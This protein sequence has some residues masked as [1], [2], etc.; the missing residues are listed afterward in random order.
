MIQSD[1]TLFRLG[2]FLILL[3][4]GWSAYTYVHPLQSLPSPIYGGDFYYQ[5]GHVHHFL[6]GGGFMESS[7]LFDAL[8]TYM[9]LY[10]WL[11]AQSA[12]L[13][14]WDAMEAMFF[15]SIIFKLLSLFLWYLLLKELFPK[16]PLFHLLGLSFVA[17]ST[18]VILKYTAFAYSIILP[19][20]L[21]ALYRFLTQRSYLNALFLGVVYGVSALSYTILFVGITLLL[22][23]LFLYEVW[24][25]FRKKDLGDYLR[26]NFPFYLVVLFSSLPLAM[27]Y[28]YHPLVDHHLHTYYNR[29]KLDFPDFGLISVQQAFMSE[30]F[31]RI[32]FNFSSP[33]GLL[34]SLLSF[35][36]IAALFLDRG[37]LRRFV[38][39][40][41]LAS[42]L[43]VFSYLITEPL[44]DTNLI[45]HRL[46]MFFIGSS[47]TLLRLY[48]LIYLIRQIPSS[49]LRRATVIG[50][51]LLFLGLGYN[52][53]TKQKE[54][55]WYQRGLQP[56]NPVFQGVGEYLRQH[57][58]AHSVVLSTK[59]LGF[60]LNAVSGI[61]LVSGRWAQ[62]GSPFTDLSLRDGHLGVILYGKTSDLRQTLLEHY[63]PRYLFWSNYWV[64][65]EYRFDRKGKV[66]GLFDPLIMFDHPKYR[67]LWD[68]AKLYY[69]SKSY[70]LD[71]SSKKPEVRRYKILIN[72]PENY[73]SL[74]RPWHPSLDPRLKKVWSYREKGKERAA[75]YQIV[76]SSPS[77]Q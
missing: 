5:L 16:E 74:H 29:A 17:F 77:Q 55:R 57:A 34:H 21:I 45:P 62:N 75:L 64:P 54:S 37:P 76:S 2:F 35:L 41:A 51:S 10:P 52:Q 61:K 36:G 20:F 18:M 49:A 60:A 7:S 50:V 46:R 8:P 71:P 43:I 39:L 23:G 38:T 56:I 4:V 72:S 73:R 14:G 15:C 12:Q 9:P 19:I 58:D 40:Y 22:S 47:A 63:H 42:L 30:T 3:L 65:S 11:T 66:V 1:K 68:D 44:F 48:G 70:W 59:E 24:N 26:S 67:K 13:F 25:A 33:L 69:F 32:F 6:Q 28:W 53:F 27:I 31:K